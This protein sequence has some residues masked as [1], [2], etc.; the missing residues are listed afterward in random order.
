LVTLKV[1]LGL[2]RLFQYKAVYLLEELISPIVTPFI[3]Y[4]VLRPK[5][6]DIVD[7]L[8]QF[9]VEVV[10][11]GDVCSFAQLDLH[12]HGQ[13]KW[14]A[15]LS[16]ASDERNSFQESLP[17]VENDIE[18]VSV[19]IIRSFKKNYVIYFSLGGRW[20]N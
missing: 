14:H 17:V 18:V 19:L 1:R 20:E 2:A 6:Q 10:G 5:A 9:T 16:Q 11:V 12:K 13:A 7:F 4:F 8:R 15:C 3:L